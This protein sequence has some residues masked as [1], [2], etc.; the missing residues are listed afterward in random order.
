MIDVLRFKN[1]RATPH[2]WRSRLAALSVLMSSAFVMGGALAQG[3][4]KPD[5][6]VADMPSQKRRIVLV[7]GGTSGMGFEDAKALAAAGAQVVLAA[8][9]PKRGQEA[10]Y[11]I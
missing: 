7:T 1:T 6:S 8:R 5:W 10:I 9:N 4:P 11:Q 2:R 3:A